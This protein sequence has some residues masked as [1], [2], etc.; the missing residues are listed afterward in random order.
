[1]SLSGAGTGLAIL[2]GGCTGADGVVHRE[3]EVAAMTGRDEEMLVAAGRRSALLVTELLTRCVRRIGAITPVTA[4]VARRLVVADRQFL[5]LKIRE[6]TFGTS[7]R[8]SI[9][10]PWAD[11][12]QRIDIEFTTSAIPVTQSADKGPE[13][14]VTLTSGDELAFRLPNGADQEALSPLLQDNEAAA[15]TG[16]LGRCVTRIGPHRPAPPELVA[17][18]PPR[19]R[20]AIERRMAEVAPRIDLTME[21]TCPECRREYSVPFEIHSFL[22]GEL[23]VNSALLRREIHY[24]AYHYHWSEREIMQMPRQRR[25]RYVSQ[26]AEEIERSHDSP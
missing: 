15:L 21:S 14:V 26:L 6:A 8:S 1:M 4:D 19:D 25:Q 2:P 20:Q 10:C 11:C 17:Q 22:F 23:S 3:A 18:L 5:L 7:V 24:L 16:L 12:A 13:Y 9:S